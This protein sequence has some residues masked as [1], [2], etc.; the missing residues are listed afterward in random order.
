MHGL[1][2]LK[3]GLVWPIGNRASVKI[4]WDSWIPHPAGHPS[5]SSQGR[6]RL[7]RVGELLDKHGVWWGDLL[8]RF[9]LPVDVQKILKIN[10]SPILGEDIL[11][12]GPE[13]NGIFTV[14]SAYTS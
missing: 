6:C 7:R 12:W 10:A 13:R 8:R 3:Q 4:W 14:H 9:F 1:E 5:I 11:A 2:L